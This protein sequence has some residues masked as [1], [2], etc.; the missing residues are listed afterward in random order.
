M[1]TINGLNSDYIT[2]DKIIFGEYDEKKYLGG[3]RRFSI[4]PATLK[5]LLNK[6]FVGANDCQNYGP[7]V[8]EFLEW[9]ADDEELVTFGGYAVTPER[10]DY[11]V[12]IDEV[13]IDIP[14]DA[15]NLVSYYVE[16]FH[17]ADEFT[18]DVHHN[19][20]HLRAWWD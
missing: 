11:R 3:V 7:M 17:A 14:L 12:A 8:C 15:Y 6:N 4:S 16:T 18:F 10:E 5:E 20:Y 13:E 1:L 9:I 19:K 2:R